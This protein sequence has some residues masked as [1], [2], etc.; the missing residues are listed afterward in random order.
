MTE[1]ASP[2]TCW[3]VSD[4]RAGIENQALG[5][6]EAVARLVPLDITVKRIAVKSPWRSLPMRIWGARP[7][8]KLD[9]VKNREGEEDP[10]GLRPPWPDLWIGSGRTSVPFSI[11]MRHSRSSFVVQTQDPR[12]GL[13]GFDLIIPPYHDGVSG[14]NVIPIHGAPTRL[15]DDMLARDAAMLEQALPALPRP[16]VAVLIGGDSKAYRMTPAV[17]ETIIATL[18]ELA[19]SGAGLMITTSRRTGEDNSA[20]LR[21]ALAGRDNVFFWG[22][23]P[24]GALANPYAGMLGLAD[25]ILVTEESTNMVTEAASTGKPVHILA[26]ERGNAKFRSFHDSLARQG[27]TKPVSLPLESWSYPPLRETDRAAK[28]IVKRWLG[29]DALASQ[30]T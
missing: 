23:K 2:K 10:A 17:M 30:Q 14:T 7:F 4:G 25:H 18:T 3:V 22:G 26:L 5:L 16:R 9:S 6:A 19:E 28:E 13:D 8:G 27:I 24:V 29:K 21:A 11:A 12:Q 15:T 1:Q 20:A